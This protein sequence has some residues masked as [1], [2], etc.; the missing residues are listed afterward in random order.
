MTAP[1][2]ASFIDNAEEVCHEL[3]LE[4]VFVA[5]IVRS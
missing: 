5:E 3:H 2:E 1:T 4:G